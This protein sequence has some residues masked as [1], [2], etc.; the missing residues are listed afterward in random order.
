MNRARVKAEER[1]DGLP[2][3]RFYRFTWWAAQDLNLWPRECES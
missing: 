3:G 1:L 2:G